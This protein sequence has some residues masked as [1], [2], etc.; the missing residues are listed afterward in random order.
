MPQLFEPDETDRALIALLRANARESNAQLA[1][2]LGLPRTTV[3]ARITRLEREGVIAGYGVRLGEQ[4]TAKI[5]AVIGIKVEPK[6]GRTVV[7]ALE[8]M[9]EIDLLV[10]VSGEVDLIAFVTV[11]A[12]SRLDLWLDTVGALDGVERTTTSIVLTTKID[13]RRVP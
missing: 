6:A 5:A 10:A 8:R 7:K 3:A 9:P 2:Q 11:E 4:R 13:R 1:R 12:T